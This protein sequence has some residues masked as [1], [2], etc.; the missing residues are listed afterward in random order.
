M[1]EHKTPGQLIVGLLKERGWTKR[2]LAIVLGVD[3]ATITRIISDKR[4]VTAELALTFEELFDVKAE[5]LLALQKDYELAKARIAFRA[6]PARALRAHIFGSLPISEM[7][8]R[9]WLHVDNPRDVL[10][11]EAEVTRFFEAE[12]S[13]DIEFLPH[14]AKRTH[15]A[16][17]ATPAQLAWLYRVKSIASEMLVPKYS[18][19]AGRAAIEKLR[20]LLVAAE[21][22]RKVPRILA[23]AGIRFVI[24]ESLPSA[25]IDGACMWLGPDAPVIGMSLRFD[26]IDNF[27]F[28]LRH[29]LEH[30]LQGHGKTSPIL[31]IDLDGSDVAGVIEEERVANEAASGF[32]V[33]KDKMTGF[34]ARK[35]PFFAERDILGFANT[36]GVHPGL[37]AGQ[38]QHRTKRYDLFRAHL[39]KIRSLVAPSA[40]VDGWGDVAPVGL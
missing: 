26:R 10:Q 30:V 11:V 15:L 19:Q 36:I 7:T 18:A 21:E 29:E 33:P 9:G 38:L 39:V 6:D 32:C 25:K 8:K 4:P 17:D 40:M 1:D 34:I 31:D 22:A 2:T 35:A 12:S 14:A 23:E 24:V 5:R 27:W 3:E 16:I 13:S 37:I 20:P 28:V